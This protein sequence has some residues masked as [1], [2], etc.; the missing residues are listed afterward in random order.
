MPLPEHSTTANLVNTL[1]KCNLAQLQKDYPSI[2]EINIVNKDF[3][4]R[5]GDHC[6]SFFWIKKGFVKLSHI[7]EQGT[8]LTLALL[9]QGNICG[10]LQSH[11]ADQVMEE[12]A[13]AL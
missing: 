1:F 2:Q 10:C 5:Q 8:E 11:S 9:K 6:S 4:Y 12:T 13:Q 3:L 7:T